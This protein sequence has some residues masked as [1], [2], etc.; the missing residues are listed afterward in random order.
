MKRLFLLSI[1]GN[2]W[3]VLTAIL[4]VS[5]CASNVDQTTIIQTKPRTI[6]SAPVA[7][8]QAKYYADQLKMPISQ[9]RL[10]EVAR[11]G[12]SDVKLLSGEDPSGYKAGL[13]AKLDS[14]DYWMVH[15]AP[16][17]LQLGGDC[18]FFIDAGTG[19]LLGVYAGR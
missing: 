13:R 15:F 11:F 19:A 4:A 17:N 18:A 3:I 10:Q 16:S 5:G 14:K 12:T 8:E 2:Q 7:V 6:T 1:C 9:K